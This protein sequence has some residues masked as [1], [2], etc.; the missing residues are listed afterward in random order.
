M[1]VPTRIYSRD[2]VEGPFAAVRLRLLD[3]DGLVQG[4]QLERG[5]WECGTETFPFPAL[6]QPFHD[7]VHPTPNTQPEC[8]HCPSVKKVEGGRIFPKCF[9]PSRVK[10]EWELILKIVRLSPF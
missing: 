9:Y 7:W 8:G 5:I 4:L 10:G 1:F 2:G 6:C 3:V